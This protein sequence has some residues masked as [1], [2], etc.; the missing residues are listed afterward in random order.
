MSTR[1]KVLVAILVVSYIAM[2]V[3]IQPGF[4]SR[5]LL[6][7]FIFCAAM[8][9]A[10]YWRAKAEKKSISGGS[11]LVQSAMASIACSV[12]LFILLQVV[13]LFLGLDFIDLVSAELMPLLILITSALFYPV[14]RRNLKQ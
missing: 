11:L 3:F 5:D 6:F 14:C 8:V 9:G 12:A 1:L 13:L 2:E 4:D 10:I 7:S